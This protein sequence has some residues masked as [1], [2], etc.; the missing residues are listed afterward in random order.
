MLHQRQRSSGATMSTTSSSPHKTFSDLIRDIIEMYVDDIIVKIKSSISLFD[1]LA[2]D[3]NRLRSMHEAEP[4][5][6]CVR[7]LYQKAA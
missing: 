4:Q 7:G 1:N 5:Q 3:F 6:M 2:L